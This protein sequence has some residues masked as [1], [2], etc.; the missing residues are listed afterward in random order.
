MRI[1]LKFDS[2]EDLPASGV[3]HLVLHLNKDRK[4][5]IGALGR[6]CFTAGYYTYT[7]RAMRGLQAR[8]A[9]HIRRDKP[10]RWHIDYFRRHARF[11]GVWGI[12][13]KDPQAEERQARALMSLAIKTVGPSALPSPGFGASDSHCP[14]H[15]FYWEDSA[16]RFRLKPPGL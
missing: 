13:S 2:P 5:T 14:A 3:Y 15:L 16:P 8:V 1:E 10:F 9:R 6:F 11:I 4:I 7:G 12:P